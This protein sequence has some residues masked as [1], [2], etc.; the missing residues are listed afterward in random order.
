MEWEC[1]S[2]YN[3][4]KN[5]A[6]LGQDFAG[7]ATVIGAG[8]MSTQSDLLPW[9]LLKIILQEQLHDVQRSGAFNVLSIAL[10]C[11]AR[12]EFCTIS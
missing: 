1:T 8:I 2:E 7:R 4:P 5:Y 6:M 9:C 12:S 10:P 11:A 3:P